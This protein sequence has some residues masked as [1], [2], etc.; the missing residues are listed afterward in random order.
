MQQPNNSVLSGNGNS[1]ELDHLFNWSATPLGDPQEWPENLRAAINEKLG[2][3][4]YL[5][6]K[7]FGSITNGV[8][9]D[10]TLQKDVAR[11]LEESEQRLRLATEA[12]ALGTFDLDLKTGEFIYSARYLR[13]FGY[14]EIIKWDSRVFYEHLHAD[15]VQI[16]KKAMEDALKTGVLNCMVRIIW[17]DGSMHWV[18]K[19]GK[20]LY[21]ATG[22]TV[23]I[24]GTLRDVTEEKT[25]IN[26]L[27]ESELLFKIISGTAPVGLWLTGPNGNC[28]FVNETWIEWT[29]ETLENNLSGGWLLKVAAEDM[30][31]TKEKFTDALVNRKY[32]NAEFRVAKDGCEIR[33]CLTEGYPY[34]G[35]DGEFAGFSGSVTDI[36]ERKLIEKELERKVNERTADLKRSEERNHRMTNEVQDYAIVLLTKEGVIENWNKGAE[37]IKGYKD[38]EIIGKNFRVFYTDE[39]REEKLPEKLIA[40]ATEHGR[41]AAEGWRVRKDGS[42]FWASIVITALHGEDNTVIGF[43][44]VTRDLTERKIS[45]EQRQLHTKELSNKNYELQKQKDFVDIILDSSIDVISVFDADMRYI[46]INRKFEEMYNVQKKH[47]I[48]KKITEVF[49]ENKTDIFRQTLERAIQG[50]SIHGF[51]HQSALTG[52]H[53]ESFL[54]PLMNNAQVYAVLAVAHDNTN[55]LEAARK[56][57]I[58]N[59]VLGEKT[60]DLQRANNALEKSNSE[61]EQYAYVASHD[62]QEPLRKIRTYSGILNENLNSKGDHSSIAILQKVINSAT[63]MS[64]LIYDLLNFSRLLNPEKYFEPTDLDKILQNVVND[65]ELVIEQKQAIIKTNR[66]PAIEAVPLQMNQLFYNLINNALKFSREGTPPVITIS[67]QKL[68]VEKIQGF[69][70][71]DSSAEYVDI[72]VTDNGIGFSQQYAGQIFEVFKRLHARQAYQGSGIGLALCRR[73]VLNHKGDIYAEGEENNGSVFHVILPL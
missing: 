71:L 72:T 30:H 53:Y 73:I 35:I 14:D 70:T 37:K 28:V 12:A 34:Y 25:A 54:I 65:F 68:P 11:E 46:S 29:G 60:E 61:L 64:N 16:A 6:P 4:G 21:D 59:Q 36:T 22:K 51:L 52:K 9:M 20:V 49:P 38:T 26:A 45:E 1:D 43:S 17:K 56:L 57:E 5:K 58:A 19:N 27:K 13:I 24:I 39:D 15:D 10:I 32:F 8:I 41:A 40:V 50:E 48:G 3:N 62:L 55:I 18:K 44:K 69:N 63:R 67:A 7:N 47:I 33:W 31:A 66:L 42:R 23:R 2:L